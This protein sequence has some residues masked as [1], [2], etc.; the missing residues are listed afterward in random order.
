MSVVPE[1]AKELAIIPLPHRFDVLQHASVRM[2]PA[3][4]QRRRALAP[5]ELLFVRN[6]GCAIVSQRARRHS[7]R[8]SQQ[9]RG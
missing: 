7:S 3:A 1:S 6:S 2:E 9:R 4:F 8:N 5:R